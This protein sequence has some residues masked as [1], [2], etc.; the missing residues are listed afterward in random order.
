[1]VTAFWQYKIFSFEIGQL[2]IS[3]LIFV[4]FLIIRKLFAHSVFAR[5]KKHAEK[6]HSRI[7]P[8]I[9]EALDKPLQLLPVALGLFLAF[10]NLKP[11]GT[12]EI[13]ASQIVRSLVVLALFWGLY[14]LIEPLS[15]LSQQLKR[16][17]SE[18]LVDFFVK[19]IKV[20]IVF[21]G[22]ATILE[23]WGIKVAPI[24]AG[25]GL[26]GVAIALGAQDLFKNLI[27]GLLIVGEK[28]FNKGDEILVEGLVEGY[29]EQLG[30]RSTLI[31]RPD[32][33]PVYIPNA[34]LSDSAVVNY[35]AKTHRRIFWH[36]G[37]E[38]QTTLAQLQEIRVEIETYILETSDFAKPSEVPTYARVDRLAE[39]S[40]DLVISCFTKSTALMDW[41]DAKERLAFKIKEIV[42][43]AGASFALPSQ[44]LYI[45]NIPAD[46]PEFFVPPRENH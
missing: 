13:F 44:T 3:T 4:G 10:A 14:N 8:H 20:L 38:Y 16:N 28:R 31:R 7:D 6:E 15:N 29:V 35:S 24:L 2:I 17:F 26:F 46:S 18:A 33:A 40:I 12:L 1:M 39:G 36:I 41:L 25:L 11:T 23:I 27:G 34:K 22:I 9:L 21:V 30:F 42:E 37:L 19:L 32:K 5:L 43:E 45:Q